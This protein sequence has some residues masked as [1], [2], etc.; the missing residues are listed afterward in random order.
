MSQFMASQEARIARFESEFNQQQTEMTNKIDN[1]LKALNN[2]VL[3]P[4]HK[5]ARTTNSGTQVRDPSSSKHAHFINVVT[6]KPIDR[7]ED[8]SEPKDEVKEVEVDKKIRKSEI[9]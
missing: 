2:Q 6:I 5:D 1:L 4:P 8:S 9:K 7:S 3:L